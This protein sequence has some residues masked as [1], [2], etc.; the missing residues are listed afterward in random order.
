MRNKKLKFNVIEKYEDITFSLK[1]LN[2][3]AQL[4]F[5]ILLFTVFP[6]TKGWIW[7]L[8]LSSLGIYILFF[9]F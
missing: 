4:L 1:T 8:I 5:F 7:F 2:R 3:F 6:K 9:E